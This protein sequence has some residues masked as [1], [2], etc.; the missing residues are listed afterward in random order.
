ME[1]ADRYGD[2]A[3]LERVPSDEMDPISMAAIAQEHGDGERLR[4]WLTIAAREGDIDAMRALILD[5]DESVEQAWVWMHLSGLLGH[6]LGQDRHVAINEDGTLYDW[7]I[8]GA[9]YVG[10]EDGINLNP[11]PIDADLVARQAAERLFAPIQRRTRPEFNA[12]RNSRT[13]ALR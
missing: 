13:L 8:G 12:E 11:L 9:A 5:P 7:D 1:T 6:D 4:Y 3:I 2:P 10:G